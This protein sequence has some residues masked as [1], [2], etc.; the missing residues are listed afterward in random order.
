MKL[1]FLAKDLRLEKWLA[2]KLI[3]NP[4]VYNES[5]FVFIDCNFNYE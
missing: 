4:H 1:H 5:L 3:V 2:I